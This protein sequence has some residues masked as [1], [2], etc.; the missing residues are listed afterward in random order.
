[1]S[2]RL[3]IDRVSKSTTTTAHATVSASATTSWVENQA[4]VSSDAVCH[5]ELSTDHNISFT[6]V[7]WARQFLTHRRLGATNLSKAGLTNRW[8]CSRTLSML[9]PRRCTSRW[10]R[11]ARRTSSSAQVYHQVCRSVHMRRKAACR[12]VGTACQAERQADR[13]A[14]RQEDQIK[15]CVT[16][17][18]QRR[19]T[20]CT[21]PS[22]QGCAAPGCPP[23]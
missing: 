7:L 13:P 3:W 22:A 16:Y 18:C 5:S 17:Q 11:R 23:G 10:M 12:R 4:K 19:C 8:Y 1:M 20:C 21:A 14:G 2:V 15:L 6:A 9:R